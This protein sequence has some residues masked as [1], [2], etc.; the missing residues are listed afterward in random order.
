MS[1]REPKGLALS[2]LIAGLVSVLM[3]V[4]F[5]FTNAGMTF[6]ILAAV[7]GIVAIVTGAIA[8]SRKQ[9]RGQA[10]TGVVIGSIC[11]LLGLGMIIFALIFV[12]A[13]EASVA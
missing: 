13:F 10:I 4:L 1:I 5:I 12:G 6:P 11:T 9:P 7:A 3:L 2:S 8:L